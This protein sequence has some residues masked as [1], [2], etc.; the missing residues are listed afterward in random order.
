[1][2]NKK[3]VNFIYIGLGILLGF[4]VYKISKDLF[5][6]YQVNVMFEYARELPRV[7]AIFSGMGLASLGIFN[8][9][10]NDFMSDVVSELKKVTWP[11]RKETYAATVVVIITLIILA[12]ILY[13]FDFVWGNVIK[14]FIA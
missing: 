7:L 13:L 14:Y 5:E 11:S 2:T 3:V 4:I 1:M 9:T 10:C 8:K 6:Y 12:L